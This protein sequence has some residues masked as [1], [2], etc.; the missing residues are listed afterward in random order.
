M[1]GL[2]DINDEGYYGLIQDKGLP[3]VIPEGGP[4]REKTLQT[5]QQRFWILFFEFF[6]KRAFL[7]FFKT[8][9]RNSRC[10]FFLC[11]ERGIRTP[12]GVTLAGFQDRCI[13]PLCHFSKYCSAVQNCERKY[14]TL[15]CFCKTFRNIFGSGS[16]LSNP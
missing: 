6:E 14:N 7:E 15:F 8:K 10:G 5:A 9:T 1:S 12:G 13:R 3:S 16:R 11:G 2:I 4:I